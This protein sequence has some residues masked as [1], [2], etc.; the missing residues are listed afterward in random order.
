MRGVPVPAGATSVRLE[1]VTFSR[2]R[3][4]LVLYLLG[5]AVFLGGAWA[6]RF[7]GRRER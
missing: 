6:V 4:A 2:S 1:Y 5:I 7:A 3:A